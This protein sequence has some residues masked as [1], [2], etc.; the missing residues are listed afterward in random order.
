MC[1]GAVL[2]RLGLGWVGPSL[3]LVAMSGCGPG[4]SE[5]PP[6]ASGTAPPTTSSVPSVAAP[7][8]ATDVDRSNPTTVAPA[9]RSVDLE[10]CDLGG[11]PGRCGSVLVPEDRTGGDGRR[12][13]PIRVAVLEGHELD[14]PDPMVFLAGGPGGSAIDSAPWFIEHFAALRG[15]RD[16]VFIEQRGVG[17]S[18][19]LWCD[20]LPLAV[21]DRDEAY[22]AGVEWATDCL[23][24]EVID[25]TR[26]D[27]A[28]F[29]DDLDDVLGRLGYGTV[30]VYGGSYGALAAQALAI[31][32][33]DRVRTLVLDGVSGLGVPVVANMPRDSQR[34]FDLLVERCRADEGCRDAYPDPH[35]DL[36]AVL[37][38]LEAKPLELDVL[39]PAS[40]EALLLDD[41]LA[42]QAVHAMLMYTD[43]APLL[44][45]AL[46][47]AAVGDVALLE[48]V[49]AS[50][51]GSVS[52]NRQAMYVTI[53]CSEPWARPDPDDPDVDSYL[54]EAARVQD[55]FY[56]G[57][58]SAWPRVGV[59]PEET[60]PP[61]TDIPAMLLVGEA[62]AQNPPSAAAV[63]AATM[64][65]SVTVIARGHGHGI[66]Q[67]GCVSGLVA[68]FVEQGAIDAAALECVGEMEPPGFL[69]P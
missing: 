50:V 39:D 22:T 37:R 35:Q 8:P 9:G 53:R 17:S 55:E 12:T 56:A 5:S 62:D 36:V 58:C 44:P 49:V 43:T 13:I 24:G 20:A 32:H 7:V 16:F 67:Y 60:T 6:V 46:T 57:V 27:T 69:L 65:S 2:G 42:A 31:R 19:A 3:L 4:S 51:V 28:S 15:D 47:A 54:T 59:E 21:R 25:V 34:A 26:Y 41:V 38:R 10:P 64:A 30:D 23:D 29:V 11:S 48:Q 45:A 52:T 68:A 18:G 14:R 63:A 66:V 33:P 61:V 1:H 40:G